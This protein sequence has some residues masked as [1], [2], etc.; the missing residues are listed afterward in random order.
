MANNLTRDQKSLFLVTHALFYISTN[1]HNKIRITKIIT[2]PKA[3]TLT[4]NPL[5]KAGHVWAQSVH[6]YVPILR[7]I[8]PAPFE[9]SRSVHLNSGL[10]AALTWIRNISWCFGYG[11]YDSKKI[12]LAISQ[13]NLL[14]YPWRFAL[15]KLL[16]GC[17]LSC[18]W[19][20]YKR[21]YEEIQT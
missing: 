20:W 4:F 12:V 17:K 8:H 7:T 3:V 6:K 15:T 10:W 21:R 16:C 13:R 18:W 1:R 2:F 11:E 9:L 14:G 5:G 19:E